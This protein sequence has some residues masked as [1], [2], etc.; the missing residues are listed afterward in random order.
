MADLRILFF[1]MPA[2]AL[3]AGFLVSISIL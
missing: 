1:V 3:M 2:G